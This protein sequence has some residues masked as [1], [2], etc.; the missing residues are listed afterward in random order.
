MSYPRSSSLLQDVFRAVLMTALAVA[1]VVAPRVVFAHAVLIHSS[2][3]EGA[4]VT[5]P[6]LPVTLKFNSRV[7]GSRSTLLLATPDGQSK[8]LAIAQQSAPDTLLANATGLIHGKYAIRWQV[9]AV[10]GHITRG[11]I[12]FEVK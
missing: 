11:Q 7:D 12:P 5:G 2:P 9:L 1:L 8:P 3:A 10:D 4:I 6:D